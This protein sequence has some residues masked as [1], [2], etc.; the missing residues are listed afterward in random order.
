MRGTFA[1]VRIKNLMLPP[2]RRRHARGRRRHA[3]PAGGREDA[4]LR[5]GDEVH[6]GRAR[7]RSSSA[8]RNTAPA[9]RATGRPRARSSSASRRS[10]RRA[11][12][13][14]TARTWSAW[15]C[16]R[17]QFKGSDTRRTRSASRAT[18][19]STSRAS[20]RGIKPQMDVT[21]AIHRKD[22]TTQSVPVLLRIDTPIEVD[23]YQQRRHPAVRAARAGRG[24]VAP[25]AAAASAGRRPRGCR[26]A[27][28]SCRRPTHPLAPGAAA[29][30]RSPGSCLTVARH[31]GE[32][33]RP[34]P[35]AVPRR[36]GALRG[37]DAGRH[38][39]RLAS[40]R[41]RLLAHAP[42][43]RCSSLRSALPAGRDRL[44]LRRPALPAAGRRLGDHVPRADLHRRA[45]A[46][47]AGR[48]ADARA[49]DRRRSP[50]SSAS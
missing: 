8:A 15:A 43:A 49:L 2:K 17:C 42:P 40:R 31:D 36:L 34:R 47:G 6:R 32:V 21:L 5:R 44:L 10:S 33:P 39:V 22:G 20:R 48:A 16:C 30:P 12:S 46:A 25:S 35:L 24:G 1:N 4:D 13:A 28:P 50:G 3:V 14:S 19:R 23:Y 11:S 45:V 37:A 38:A 41:A 18:R 7:R 9:A 27:A 26:P 29:V